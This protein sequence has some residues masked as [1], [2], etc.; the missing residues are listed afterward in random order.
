M[1]RR[2]TSKHSRHSSNNKRSSRRPKKEQAYYARNRTPIQQLRAKSVHKAATRRFSMY[3][4]SAV[5]PKKRLLPRIIA[6]VVVVAAVVLLVWWLAT[7]VFG[8]SIPAEKR[9]VEAGVAVEVTIPEGA[10]TQ[11]IA[12]ILYDAN[13]AI[14]QKAFLKAVASYD[15]STSLK[16]GT[17]ELV[18]V[19]DANELV[20]T[21]VAGPA[22]Y[23]T[24]LTIPEG[25]RIDEIA[26]IVETTLDI[27]QSEFLELAG[28][29]DTYASDYPFLEGAYDNSLEGYL[30]P[31]TYDVLDGATADDVIRMMLD[32][33]EKELSAV[34]ISTSSATDIVV[35]AAGNELTLSELVTIASMIEGETQVQS[36]MATVASVIYNRLAIPMR[37]QIDATVVYALGDSYTGDSVTYSDLEVDSPYNTYQNDGL[38]PGPISSPGI[39]TI[40]AAAN[41]DDTNYLYYVALGTDGTHSF[42][43]DYDS[44]LA[45]QQG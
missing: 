39:D 32:Q 24:K 4:T 19:M 40:V 17:Y 12:D 45:A 26:E 44:F 36:E 18:T 8:S 43:E 37:L 38:P 34:G 6:I 7:S 35:T 2:Y 29:A 9:N 1:S 41:P 28:S 30:F 15:A 27:S 22:F 13:V 16:P 25:L 31:K 10:S 14:D 11:E 20:E 3:D 33:F 42:F 23:G 5:R 21:L